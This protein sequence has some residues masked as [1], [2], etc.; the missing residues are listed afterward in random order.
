MNGKEREL[1]FLR[2]EN[3]PD[4]RETRW[5]LFNDDRIGNECKK[6]MRGRCGIKIKKGGQMIKYS[7]WK[8]CEGVGVKIKTGR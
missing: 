6:E 3:S 8:E 4:E 2:F 7:R 5:L 1:S